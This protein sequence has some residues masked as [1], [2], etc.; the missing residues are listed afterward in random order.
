[1][2]CG[3]VKDLTNLPGARGGVLSIAK[4]Q[5]TSYEKVVTSF[6]DNVSFC[7]GLNA[8]SH[9]PILGLPFTTVLISLVPQSDSAIPLIFYYTMSSQIANM[10]TST[11]VAITVGTVVTG[12]LGT[13]SLS[14]KALATGLFFAVAFELG[15]PASPRLTETYSLRSLL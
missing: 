7:L 10:K 12:F 11:I 2:C 1:M 8:Y 3:L 13:R 4:A 6:P 9:G 14:P 15:L 5:L